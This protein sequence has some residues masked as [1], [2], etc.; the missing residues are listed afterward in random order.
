M[1]L[2]LSVLLAIEFGLIT[3]EHGRGLYVVLLA[4][5][6]LGPAGNVSE[7]KVFELVVS[8]VS[9]V[10]KV[11]AQII[12]YNPAAHAFASAS[13]LCAH[14]LVLLASLELQLDLVWRYLALQIAFEIVEARPLVHDPGASWLSHYAAVIAQ[15]ISV[16]VET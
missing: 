4:L 16:I 14:F 2:G 8:V 6:V 15:V 9:V 10:V 13:G 11:V 3:G 7:A 1:A 5:Q 12:E